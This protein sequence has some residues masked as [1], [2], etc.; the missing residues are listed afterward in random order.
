[1]Y[2]EKTDDILLLQCNDPRIEQR[3]RW[4][5]GNDFRDTG[6]GQRAQIK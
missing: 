5:D 3:R 2:D 4:L 6:T 1:M